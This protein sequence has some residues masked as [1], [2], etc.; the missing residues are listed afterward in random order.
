MSNSFHADL[1][2]GPVIPPENIKAICSQLHYNPKT[3][4]LRYCA[5]KTKLEHKI[6]KYPDYTAHET[7]KAEQIAEAGHYEF[8]TG[9]PYSSEY[10][11]SAESSESCE[12]GESDSLESLTAPEDTNS[13]IENDSECDDAGAERRVKF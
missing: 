2:G 9:E 7:R 13:E 11:T 4:L 6:I 5:P 1:D 12:S 10:Q 3:R 8:K